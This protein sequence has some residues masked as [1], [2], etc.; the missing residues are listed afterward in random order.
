MAQIL[1]TTGVAGAAV[2]ATLPA[3]VA[4][5]SHKIIAVEITMY[6]TAARTGTATPV[7]VTTTN[8]PGTWAI[9]F[10]TAGAIGTT[11]VYQM[12]VSPHEIEVVTTGAASTI[13]CP[14]TASVI[15]RITVVYEVS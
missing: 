12:Q 13:V 2:T 4:G 8:I 1:S 11:V 9:T 14:A 3:P 5:Q 7:T 15:W 6:N 10:P